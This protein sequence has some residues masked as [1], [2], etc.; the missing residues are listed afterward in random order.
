MSGSELRPSQL[1]ESLHRAG[2]ELEETARLEGLDQYSPFGRMIVVMRNSL[3]AYA[4]VSQLA[5]EQVERNAILSRESSQAIADLVAHA[6]KIV[7]GVR[8]SAE[9]RIKGDEKKHK[10][11]YDETVARMMRKFEAEVASAV[12]DKIKERVPFVEQGFYEYAR[13]RFFMRLVLVG[14]AI[15]ALSFL[16]GVGFYWRSIE[17]GN[18]CLDRSNVSYADT[19]KAWCRLPEDDKLPATPVNGS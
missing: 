16:S 4:A 18:H 7:E 14:A 2:L 9:L 17:V 19:G 3:D 15:F 1:I 13:N 5:L 10:D 12:L 6:H 8:V 11:L